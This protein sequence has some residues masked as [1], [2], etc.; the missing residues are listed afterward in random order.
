MVWLRDGN[1][2]E[3]LCDA[4]VWAQ[5]PAATDLLAAHRRRRSFAATSGDLSVRVTAILV[6]DLNPACPNLLPDERC[7]IHDRRPLVCRIYPAEINPFIELRPQSKG[8]PPEAWSASHPLLTDDQGHLDD[9]MA[10]DIRRSRDTDALEV[11]VKARL[12]ALLGIT[13]A[14]LSNEG[15]IHYTPDPVLLL[16]ALEQAAAAPLDEISGGA[17]ELVSNQSATVAAL[18]G[19]SA[20]AS[21]EQPTG[22]APAYRYL[23]FNAPSPPIANQ[24]R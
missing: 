12:C 22:T 15:F 14:A 9:V 6:G 13:H 8:C 17:W 11:P 16:A 18:T 4:L 7:A 20:R 3:I 5:E 19:M 10:Q 23:G 1:P 2:V 21:H 24:G